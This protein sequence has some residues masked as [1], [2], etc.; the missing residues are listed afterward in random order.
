MLQNPYKGKLI[1][2]DGPNG[3]GKSTIIERL[4]EK[5]KKLDLPVYFT[6]EPSDSKIGM[7]TRQFSEQCKG[8]SVACLVGADRYYHLEQ[9][10]I[11]RLKAGDLVF[12]DRYILSSLILQGMDE[13]STSLICNINSE[14]IK[15]DLQIAIWASK[16]TLQA[17]LKERSTLTRFEKEDQSERELIYMQTGIDTLESMGVKC[18]TIYNDCNLNKNVEQ[19]ISCVL[20]LGGNNE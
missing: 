8:A 20:N 5:F 7:F 4:K 2:I 9:E 11:P 19:I 18:V 16:D 14:I 10:L 13:V 1:A 6:R 15:P 17:R 3:S 12:T